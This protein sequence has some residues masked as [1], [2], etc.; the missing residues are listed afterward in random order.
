MISKGCE[1]DLRKH[2]IIYYTNGPDQLQQDWALGPLFCGDKQKR[3]VL[4]VLEE[5][6]DQP[7]RM[8]WI[9]SLLDCGDRFVWK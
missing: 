3:L 7:R 6:I 2:L 5:S 1:K 4:N 8:I 9:H